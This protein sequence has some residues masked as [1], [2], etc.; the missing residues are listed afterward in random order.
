MSFPVDPEFKQTNSGKNMSNIILFDVLYHRREILFAPIK[1]VVSK[2]SDFEELFLIGDSCDN[3]VKFLELFFGKLRKL[4]EALDVILVELFFVVKNNVIV[5]L[6][7]NESSV[8]LL[9]GR[10]LFGVLLDI[11]CIRLHGGSFFHREAYQ[12]KYC[13]NCCEDC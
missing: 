2:V 6:V 7:E 1:G 5:S 8:S 13:H 3:V 9:D 10:V 12:T 4:V 11:I